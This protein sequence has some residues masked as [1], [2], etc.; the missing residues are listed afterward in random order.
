MTMNHDTDGT[1]WITVRYTVDVRVIAET[2]DEA[3]YHA[4]LALPDYNLSDWV[5]TAQVVK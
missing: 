1:P 2:N 3:L 4:E 5:G